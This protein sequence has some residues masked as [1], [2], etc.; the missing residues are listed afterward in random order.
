MQRPVQH[1]HRRRCPLQR[2]CGRSL[3][4]LLYRYGLSRLSKG[5]PVRSFSDTY[6]HGHHQSVVAQHAAR[7]AE[8]S[9]AYLLPYLQQHHALLDVG[10]GPGTITVGL[11]DRVCSVEAVDNV[12]AILEQARARVDGRDNVRFSEASAYELPFQ[13][14]TFDV[15]HCHQVLQH[16]SDPISALREMHRVCKPGGLVAA[17]ESIYSTMRGE[18]PGM[19]ELDRWRSIYMAVCQQNNAEPDAGRFVQ[20]WM[21]NAGFDADNVNFSTS[22]VTYCSA[23]EQTRAAWGQAWAERSLHSAFADQALAY[24]I[25]QSR[26][27]L[28]EVAT[29]WR[30]WADDPTSVYFYVN[31]QVLGRKAIAK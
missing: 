13:D 20:R 11:A 16:L 17:R 4:L 1:L 31:G 7:T 22:V 28:E 12:A 14:D 23:D 2:L 3:Q 15:V 5:M 10:C 27:E 19:A 9:A 8:N 30:Q 25:V 29:G 24:H 18:G 26:D 6:T 21:I